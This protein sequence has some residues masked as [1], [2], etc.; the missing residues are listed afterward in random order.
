MEIHVRVRVV[1]KRQ[2]GRS[3]FLEHVEILGLLGDRF[4]VDEAI[5]RRRLV[6]SQR[7]DNAFRDFDSRNAG[8][9]RAMRWEIV[10]SQCDRRLRRGNTID[11]RP[12]DEAAGP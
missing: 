12:C 2:P 1:G 10:E 9:Q 3:P 8:R 7:L 5:D 4:G 11:S 6:P